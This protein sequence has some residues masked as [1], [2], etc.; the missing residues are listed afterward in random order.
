MAVWS[1]RLALLVFLTT[2]VVLVGNRLGS[3][4]NWL[5]PVVWA[6]LAA[7]PLV[8]RWRRRDRERGPARRRGG[9]AGSGRDRTD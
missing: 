8:D 2:V 9:T 3:P 4:W 6:L 5:L 7:P 1:G